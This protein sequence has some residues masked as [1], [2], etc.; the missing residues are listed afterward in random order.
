MMKNGHHENS[1]EGYFTTMC[2]EVAVNQ[3][4]AEDVGKQA[5]GQTKVVLLC[6]LLV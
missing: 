5:R 2:F 6:Q 4:A 1:T 3:R